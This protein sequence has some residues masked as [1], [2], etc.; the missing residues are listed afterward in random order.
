MLNSLDLT[1]NLNIGVK[2][3]AASSAAAGFR[4]IIMPI[5]TVKTTMQVTGKFSAVVDKVELVGPRALYNGALAAA[6]TTFVG[7]Y[8]YVLCITFN[9]STKLQALSH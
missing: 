6:S 7:H 3:V 2:T 1:K 5:D 8:P 9:M 4:I